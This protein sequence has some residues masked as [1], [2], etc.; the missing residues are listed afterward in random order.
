MLCLFIRYVCIWDLYVIANNNK[1]QAFIFFDFLIV[2]FLSL[3]EICHSGDVDKLYILA[4]ILALLSIFSFSLWIGVINQSRLFIMPWIWLKYALVA[5][6][7]IRFVSIV[8]ELSANEKNTVGAS[9]IFELL[10]LGERAAHF[11]GTKKNCDKVKFPIDYTFLFLLCKRIL[12]FKNDLPSSWFFSFFRLQCFL[13]EYNFGTFRRNWAIFIQAIS[14]HSSSVKKGVEGDLTAVRNS[15]V[16]VIPPP[17]QYY[18][19]AS[20]KKKHEYFR[21]NFHWN[22]YYKTAKFFYIFLNMKRDSATQNIN[23]IKVKYFLYQFFISI[24]VHWGQ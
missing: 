21:K 23:M 3:F 14:I 16:L 12:F 19:R 24:L 17:T 10:I 8:V 22:L 4:L 9:P 13:I 2:F 5:L 6:Q 11:V 18:Q 20:N 1:I 15:F 7:L